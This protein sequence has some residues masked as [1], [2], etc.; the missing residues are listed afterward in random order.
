M[1]RTCTRGRVDDP[2]SIRSLKRFLAEYDNGNLS[3]P[4]MAEHKSRK[5]V[6][7]GSGP[8]GLT[9]GHELARRD[10]GWKSL[11]PIPSRAAC[12][13]GPFPSSDCQEKSSK[14]ISSI[15]KEWGSNVGPIPVSGKTWVGMTFK[16]G[17]QMR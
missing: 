1:K 3:L 11:N 17:R 7:V 5:V 9:A 16:M 14:G 8:A 12:S 13:P 10:M 2:L 4:A 6:I 15:S